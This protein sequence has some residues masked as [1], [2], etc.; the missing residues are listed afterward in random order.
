MIERVA[1]V[2]FNIR[3]LSRN[4]TILWVKDIKGEAKDKVVPNFLKASQGKRKG[5][6]FW[7]FLFKTN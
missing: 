5:R 7:N 1:R 6:G 4:G 3:I 2:E